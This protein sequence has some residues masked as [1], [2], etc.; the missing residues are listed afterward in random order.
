MAKSFTMKWK[1]ISISSKI[2]RMTAQFVQYL[3]VAIQSNY[4]ILL[5]LHFPFVT[6]GAVIFDCANFII[7]KYVTKWNEYFYVLSK[8]YACIQV[9]AFYSYCQHTHYHIYHLP[10][11]V[12]HCYKLYTHLQT[13]SLDSNYVNGNAGHFSSAMLDAVRC[14]ICIIFGLS[15]LCGSVAQQK[16]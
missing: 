11:R 1:L 12:S 4:I 7:E 10:L 2:W 9:A 13:L 14:L 15:G 6:I 3:Q 16:L 8:I 5:F